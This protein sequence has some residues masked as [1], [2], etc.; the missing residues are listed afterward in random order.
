MKFI[1][2][3]VCF[4][5]DVATI[6]GKAKWL[7]MLNKIPN[8]DVPE[9]ICISTEYFERFLSSHPC[10]KEIDK[11]RRDSLENPIHTRKNL[12][13]IREIIKDSEL[14]V[15]FLED[16]TKDLNSL[17]ISLKDGI[18][19]RSSSQCEDN[20]KRSY[21]GIFS[22]TVNVCNTKALKQA[23][24]DTWASQFSE[25][26]YV[27]DLESKDSSMAIVIQKMI[28]TNAYGVLFS[29]SPNDNRYM[30]IERGNSVSQIVDGVGAE[31]SFLVNRDTNELVDTEDEFVK[32]FYYGLINNTKIIEKAFDMYCDIE[33]AIDDKR[34]Y[35]LQC[36]PLTKYDSSFD[37]KIIE[38]GD[39]ESCE[40]VYLGECERYYN[41]FLGKQY[42]FRREVIKNGFKVYKQIF[43]VVNKINMLKK[44]VS[45]C[46][47]YF[48]DS[49]FVIVEFGDK[50]K[51]I[52]CKLDKLEESLSKAI[53]DYSKVLCCVIG[54]LI[55]ADKSGYCCI[56]DEGECL[57]EYTKG[58]MSRIQK[59]TSDPIKVL[60]KNGKAS[61]ISKPCIK[62]IDTV[63][64]N[65]GERITVDF[66]SKE[67]PYLSETEIIALE[68]FTNLMGNSFQ[69]AS[70][71]WYSSLENLYGKDI[72]VESNTIYYNKEVQNIISQGSA[73]GVAYKISD[74]KALD[75][76]SEEYHLSLYAHEEGDY[77]VLND[78]K[79]KKIIEELKEMNK[80][81]IF[82]E[83]PSNGILSFANCIG[84][85]VFKYGSVL[86]HIGICM[87]EKKIPACINEELYDKVESKIT[88]VE[89]K[90][91]Y[92]QIL[93]GMHK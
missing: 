59:G 3:K 71:E 78:N 2:L 79:I 20:R 39:L 69:R 57:I 32:Q 45:D 90:N 65:T 38:Y 24:L 72:S 54:E 55:K 48:S 13:K 21:A 12:S 75:S 83:R 92:P 66:E 29:K 44:A 53:K 77:M 82:A 93:K 46:R 7:G 61:Y 25:V 84:G 14:S 50:E 15:K 1:D 58:R 19:V 88:M 26:S 85:C 63:D 91:G 42:I 56:N 17:G 87:R 33:W 73:V 4:N 23:I 18:A 28:Y 40:R 11:L 5:E 62:K 8:I 74:L 89:I 86:S 16:I 22:S 9:G 80:P 47:K 31:Q 60:I 52:T 68:N 37:Y 51:T 43:L 49:E 81:I 6:G 67:Y 27:Y 30:L 10:L 35:I 76:I 70:F 64:D 34:T 36:R 41:K